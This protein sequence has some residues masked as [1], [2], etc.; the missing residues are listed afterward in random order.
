MCDFGLAHLKLGS[1]V[2]TDR[3]GSPMW[4]APEVLKGDARDEKADTYS[5]A[6]L[7]FELLTRQLP[8]GGYAAAQVVMGVITNL[9]PRPEL[10]ADAAH[11]PP[12]LAALMR[13]CWAFE[14]KVSADNTSAF[15]TFTSSPC[16]LICTPLPCQ[17]PRCA[18]TSHAS[19][20]HSRRSL[21]RLECPSTAPSAPRELRR[22]ARGAV[23]RS[24]ASGS[25]RTQR[26]SRARRIAELVAL[27][28]CL[29]VSVSSRLF[30][31]PTAP[32]SCTTCAGTGAC[33]VRAAS[34]AVT[35][36]PARSAREMLMIRLC[37]LSIFFRD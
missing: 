15:N 25:A 7:L 34:R 3:M 22:C 2:R 20:T 9:L 12:K 24:A 37:V 8:Y 5:Y 19:S 14:A 33:T 1:D 27:R 29:S 6:M 30:R 31:P 13:E 21:Q 17:P 28:S 32:A 10:P 4:T 26:R 16:A 35:P 18:P 11:Y 36:R 23:Q